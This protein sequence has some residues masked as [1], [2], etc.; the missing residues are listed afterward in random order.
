MKPLHEQRK[1]PQKKLSPGHPFSIFFGR[2]FHV[3]Q[4]EPTKLLG[5]QFGH[6]FR[7]AEMWSFL[8]GAKPNLAPFSYDFRPT[9][10]R[11]SR[12]A[13]LGLNLVSTRQ[14]LVEERE[15][16]WFGPETRR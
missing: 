11:G 13:L 2:N 6:L 1:G 10:F 7:Q 12:R 8:G 3:H 5:V 14:G 16:N 4:T 9:F 15:T